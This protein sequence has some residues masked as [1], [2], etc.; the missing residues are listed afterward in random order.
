MSIPGD[1]TIARDKTTA[2]VTEQIAL[3][4]L[5]RSGELCLWLDATGHVVEATDAGCRWLG[6]RREELVGQHIGS[7]D[8]QADPVA[9]AA[10]WQ[11]MGDMWPR[12][13]DTELL[14]KDGRKKFVDASVFRLTGLEQDLQCCLFRDLSSRRDTEN[15]FRTVFERGAVAM[16]V[17]NLEGYFERVNSAFQEVLGYRNFNLRGQPLSDIV[18]EGQ[19]A[20][21]IGSLLDSNLTETTELLDPGQRECLL[22]HIDGGLI[23]AL[24]ATA[25]ATNDIGQ[26][27]SI[28]LQLQDITQ[29]KN[30]QRELNEARIEAEQASNAKSA[31]L[32]KMSHEFRTPLNGVLGMNELLS[33]TELDGQ[34][35]K[36]TSLVKQS[37]E[38]LLQVI[39]DILDFSKIEA[40]EMRLV[41]EPY[42][43]S[44][45]VEELTSFYASVA[46]LKGISLECDL[47]DD[48][49]YEHS[50]DCNRLRQVLNN[51]IGNAIKFTEKGEVIVGVGY[52]MNEDRGWLE[53]EVRDTGIGMNEV[54]LERVMGPFVQAD[55]G[56]RRRHD[57]TGLGLTIS[58]ELIQLMNGTLCLQSAPGVGTT[59]TARVPSTR[60]ARLS[61]ICSDDFLASTRVLIADPNPTLSQILYRRLVA[62]SATCTMVSTRESMLVELE[63]SKDQSSPYTLV[64]ADD[65]FVF[66]PVERTLPTEFEDA[67][68]LVVLRALGASN[69]EPEIG[70]IQFLT[71]PILS[72]TLKA[73]IDAA[74][75]SA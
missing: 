45:L 73:C 39:N 74:I 27:S 38:A 13:F 2:A 9:F 65:S 6:Y 50:G 24:V 62:W 12:R 64:F 30:V 29:I 75:D 68:S 8:P 35:R 51:L 17:L 20:Q 58:S 61:P 11:A 44:E 15:M 54:E 49:H 22:R 69:G 36:F 14:T 7:L 71:R 47:A 41:E 33:R 63:R 25:I 57:G 5:Q 32:S 72:H 31:F 37:A 56:S 66:D 26:P 40:G 59:V 48:L 16:A 28:I 55:E 23:W 19:Q 70:N 18:V 3:L 34:Q 52:E 43:P 60:I 42:D 4:S 21:A 10:G 46:S 1:R 53:F 67:T